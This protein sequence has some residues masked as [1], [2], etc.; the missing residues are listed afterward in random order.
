MEAPTEMTDPTAEPLVSPEADSRVIEPSA[1]QYNARLVR[2]IDQ[3]DDLAYFWVKFE[4]EPVPFEPGQYM[5]IGVFADEPKV[6]PH[7]HLPVQSGSDA[8][9]AR[10]RRDYTV[11]GYLERLGKLRAARP[12]IAAVRRRRD[13]HETVAP[14]RRRGA[15]ELD[16]RSRLGAPARPEKHRPCGARHGARA[17][18]PPACIAGHRYWHSQTL[19]FSCRL[20]QQFGVPGKALGLDSTNAVNAYNNLW[21]QYAQLATN[22]TRTRSTPT[23]NLFADYRVQSGKLKGLQIGGGLRIITHLLIL[24]I[25]N[26]SF[27]VGLCLQRINSL[28]GDNIGE[29]LL[30]LCNRSL[31]AAHLRIS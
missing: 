17:H 29:V 20:L 22:S 26:P 21:I 4:G 16:P 24:L 12:G 31:I 13:R 6:M 28:R 5:T 11:A 2:R 15:Q 27:L 25:L 7:F 10:M 8:V 30:R 1:E 9:L 14:R 19:R 18:P 3:T 23:M